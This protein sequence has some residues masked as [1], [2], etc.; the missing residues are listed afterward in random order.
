[1]NHIQS[2]IT[3]LFILDIEITYMYYDYAFLGPV[4]PLLPP[5]MPPM[6][7]DN[8][9]NADYSHNYS[10]NENSWPSWNIEVLKKLIDTSYKE[11][12]YSY[13]NIFISTNYNWIGDAIYILGFYFYI[14]Y[15]S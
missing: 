10:R 8:C 4:A 14:Y 3:F 12:A 7:M 9:D 15:I 1:M 2:I 6:M 11:S 13:T 5:P